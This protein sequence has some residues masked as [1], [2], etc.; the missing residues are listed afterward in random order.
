M[1]DLINIKG[2]KTEDILNLLDF[3]DEI[4]K[5][6]IRGEDY[7][8]PLKDKTVITSF[9]PTS[10]RTR[11]SFEVGIFQLGGNSIN[12]PIDFEGK[13]PLED[14][15][16]YLNCWIDYLVIRCKNQEIIEE[17]AKKGKFSVINAM[18]NLSHPCEILSDLQTIREKR[19]NLQN[20]KFV[21]V[22]E[23]HNICNTWFEAAA[24]LNLNLTQ[25]CPKGYEINKELFDYARSKSKGDIYTTNNLQEGVKDADIILTDGWPVGEDNIEEFN[26]FLPY[27]LSLDKIKGGNRECLINPC[28]PFTRG[29]EITDEII[30]SKHFIGY[31]C[32]ENLL[33]MQ[34]AIIASLY[35]IP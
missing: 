17:I 20:L 32:K 21:F 19:G 28:P 26:K 34:K 9:P 4:K 10:M 12:M 3:A 29:H 22:G 1:K 25:V 11:I 30:K 2:L 5:R 8:K 13:E 24:K 18:T 7:Y 16:G 6:Q 27:R 23:G 14:K 15:V 31:S 33:H 35:K